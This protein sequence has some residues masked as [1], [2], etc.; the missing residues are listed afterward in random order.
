L[1]QLMADTI[2]IVKTENHPDGLGV[3]MGRAVA[4]AAIE[5]HFQDVA[6]PTL[7][8]ALERHKDSLVKE[9]DREVDRRLGAQLEELVA[10]QLKDLINAAVAKQLESKGTPFLVEVHEGA[11][12]RTLALP[13][14]HFMFPVLLKLLCALDANNQPLNIGMVGPAGNGKTSMALAAAEALA[15][16]FVLQPFNPQSTRS[17]LLGY[18][19]AGGRYVE[20]PFY[21][22]FRDGKLYIADEF[23]AANP[24]VALLLNAAIA[25]RVLTFPNGET[26]RAHPSFRA[27]FA[28]NTYGTGADHQYTGRFRQDAATLDRLVYLDVPIDPGLEASLAKLENVTSPSVDITAGGRFRNSAEVFRTVQ[29]IRKAV[30]GQN[31]NYLISPRAT[32]YACAM[33]E[34][35]FGKNWTLKCCVWRGMPETDLQAIKSA[36]EKKE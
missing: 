10:A 21:K 3:L 22:A 2:D 25:N 9:V 1:E 28:M 24:S 16:P 4:G 33:H 32:L 27:I 7:A 30:A 20:S 29:R 14:Q 31:M 35:G 12:L 17:D 8:K 34:A 13:R 19:D 36:L 23:D 6:L 18:M 15:V 11:R 5:D 26:L